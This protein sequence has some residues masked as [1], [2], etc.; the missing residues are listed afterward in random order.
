LEKYVENE[1]AKMLLLLVKTIR[2]LNSVSDCDDPNEFTVSS[3]D[4]ARRR[5][6]LVE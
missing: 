4:D 1:R 3:V 5:F 6:S 2:D